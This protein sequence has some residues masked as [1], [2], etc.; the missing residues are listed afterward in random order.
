MEE[1]EVRSRAEDPEGVEQE[2]SY[3]LGGYH[4]GEGAGYSPLPRGDG[5]RAH[6]HGTEYARGHSVSYGA[7]CKLG[8]GDEEDDEEGELNICLPDSEDPGD[9]LSPCWLLWILLDIIF[10]HLISV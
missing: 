8:L 4:E 1:A 3:E 10:R 5:D 6:Y 2:A 7:A 9:L